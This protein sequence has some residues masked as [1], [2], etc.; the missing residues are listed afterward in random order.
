MYSSR[1]G[2]KRL[3]ILKVHV[4][5]EIQDMDTLFKRT[6]RNPVCY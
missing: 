4:P 3:A 5:L 1:A 6:G 2:Q